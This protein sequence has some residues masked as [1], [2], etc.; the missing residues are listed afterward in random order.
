MLFYAQG[1][2]SS[3]RPDLSSPSLPIIEELDSNWIGIK[4]FS[5]NIIRFNHTA[6]ALGGLMRFESFSYLAGLP[7]INLTASK[8][9]SIF[10][11]E[12]KGDNALKALAK[13]S[14]T[15]WNK[16]ACLGLNILWPL[17]WWINDPIYGD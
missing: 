2:V 7:R 5:I 1:P 13:A 15:G 3:F 16:L 17:G 9:G 12:I 14:I 8:P 10:L 6:L 11:Y 4:G